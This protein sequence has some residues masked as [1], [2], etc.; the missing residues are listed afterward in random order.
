MDFHQQLSSLQS[1]GIL[2][3][4]PSERS[5]LQL[6]WPDPLQT[7]NRIVDIEMP[8]KPEFCLF[9]NSLQA[10]VLAKPDVLLL[11]LF[12]DRDVPPVEPPSS[13]QGYRPFAAVFALFFDHV[14]VSMFPSRYDFGPL[15]I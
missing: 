14:A 6:A 15:E 3:Y 7:T 2:A 4:K 1:P 5:T 9:Q 12:P 13:L 10:F 11:A 8:R